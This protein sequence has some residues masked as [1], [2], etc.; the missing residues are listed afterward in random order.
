MDNGGSVD[1]SDLTTLKVDARKVCGAM[2]EQRRHDGRDSTE[3]VPQQFVHLVGSR[4]PNAHRTA[5][6][7]ARSQ[8]L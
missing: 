2:A 1:V 5:A 3:S 8:N 4:D 7:R 6:M